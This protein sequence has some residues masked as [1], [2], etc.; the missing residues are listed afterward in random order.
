MKKGQKIFKVEIHNGTA[1]EIHEEIVK[2]AGMKRLKLEDKY[3]IGNTYYLQNGISI[4]GCIG[5]F[6]NQFHETKAEF[7]W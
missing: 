6:I 7:W 2:S 1:I 3:G 4:I 5:N